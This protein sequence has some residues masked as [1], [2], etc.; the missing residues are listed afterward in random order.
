MPDLDWLTARPIA[1]RGLHDVDAGIIENTLSAAEAAIAGTYGIELDVQP[2]AEDEPVVFH[3]STLNRVT[4]GSGPVSALA[5]KDLAA[6]ALKHT[7]DRIVTLSTF[8]EAV[9]GRVPVVVEIKGGWSNQ[10]GFFAKTAAA[11]TACKGPVAVMSFD[12]TAVAFFRKHRPGIPRGITAMRFGGQ[13]ARRLSPLQRF[14]LSHMLHALNTRPHFIAYNTLDL[15]AFAPNLLRRASGLPVLTWT[16][17]SERER[18]RTAPW[19]DQVIF[20]GF[21]P[22]GMDP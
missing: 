18:K 14:V 12:P 15:P 11:L 17:R 20:E 22:Q 2:D 13:E 6:I 3:D 16:V 5:A 4:E 10:T 9:G 21:I 19:A 1:H 7:G 8:L